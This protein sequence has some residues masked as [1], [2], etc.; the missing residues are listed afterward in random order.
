MAGLVSVGD[1]VT[2][3]T[4]DSLVNTSEFCRNLPV[5]LA[6]FT[7]VPGV[8]W[9][10]LEWF[11]PLSGSP[12]GTEWV[13]LYPAYSRMATLSSWSDNGDDILSY[14]DTIFFENP[15]TGLRNWFHVELVTPTIKMVQVGNDEDTVYM[16]GLDENPLIEPI[17]EPL[18][19]YWHGV[20][21]QIYYCKTWEI[22]DWEDNGNGYLDSCDMV[23]MRIAS[24]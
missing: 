9:H 12:L 8:I 15:Q 11:T 22:I 17:Y 19:T 13:E 14:C 23:D 24:Q 20:H 2:A 4:T 7:P 18:G 21:P 6:I 1:T 10:V 5:S 16:E 3:T